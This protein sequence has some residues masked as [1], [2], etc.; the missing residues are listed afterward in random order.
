MQVKIEN[1]ILKVEM[2]L[3]TPRPTS[4]GANKNLIVGSTGGFATTTAQVGGKPVKIN[5]TA[6]IPA[7]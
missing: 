5:L 7:S 2:P 1:G 3:H 6:M 4:N